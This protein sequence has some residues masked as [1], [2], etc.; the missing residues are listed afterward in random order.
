MNTIKDEFDKFADQVIAKDAPEVQ[1][2]EMQLAF[3]AGT[4]STLMLIRNVIANPSLS[5][6][7]SVNLLMNWLNES[8]DFIKSRCML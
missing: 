2:S 4:F 7:A 6:D 5:E 1:I 8:N 3:Y